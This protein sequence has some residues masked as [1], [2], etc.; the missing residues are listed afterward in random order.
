MTKIDQNKILENKI[1]AN[2]LDFNLNRQSAILSAFAD[3]NFDKYEYLTRIDL[4]LK[5]NSL[6]ETRIE[7]SPLGNLLNKK[8]KVS[9]DNKN[10]DNE[11]DDHEND[12]NENDDHENDIDLLNEMRNHLNNLPRPALQLPRQQSDLQTQTVPVPS[13]RPVQQS[14]LQTQTVPVSSIRPVQQSDLQTQTVPVPSTRPVQQSDVQTQTILKQQ[15]DLQTQT[16][17]PSLIESPI[18]PTQSKRASFLRPLSPIQTN[19]RP[20]RPLSPSPIPKSPPILQPPVL[21]PPVLQP[22][23]SPV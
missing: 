11:N 15:S 7:Y 1:R 17:L 8:L 13:T 14:V 21:Q 22:P 10:D 6:Q 3:G 2:T 19:R 20:I 18:K 4:A 9:D 12:D 5:P 23:L 16:S